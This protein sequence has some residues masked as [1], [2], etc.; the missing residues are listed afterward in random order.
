MGKEYS[1][2]VLEKNG[3]AFSDNERQLIY[4]N[5]RRILTTRKGER[6]NE[7]NFGSNLQSFLFS[8]QMYLD[9]VLDEIKFSIEANEPRVKV[10]ACTIS[11]NQN[12]EVTVQ[13]SLTIFKENF[14][15]ND[16]IEVKI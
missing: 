2:Y 15:T 4:E 11:G 12:D 14:S 1:G 9:N 13:L 7:P 5:I 10:R 6:V 16:N 3:I 8:P